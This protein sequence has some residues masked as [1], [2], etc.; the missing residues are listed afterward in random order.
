LIAPCGSLSR[1]DLFK[2]EAHLASGVLTDDLANGD[3]LALF[4]YDSI[5]R[6]H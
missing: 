3:W 5:I 2:R 4:D 1:N 6:D